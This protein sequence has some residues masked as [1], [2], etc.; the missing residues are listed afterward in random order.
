V[1]EVTLKP[2]SARSRR[3]APEERRKQ[4]V[5]AVIEVVAERGVPGAT[6]SRIA[7]A[8]GV[9][10]GTLYVY[11]PSRD[12]MLVAA[13]DSIFMQMLGL[14]ESSTEKDPVARLR[15]I[16]RRHSELMR[17][18][19]GGFLYPWIEFIAAG[20]LV[21]LREEVA[22]TQQRAFSKMLSIVEQGQAEGT[23]RPDL[24]AERLTWEW[25]TI[26]WAENMSC[27]MGLTEFIDDHHSEYLLELILSDAAAS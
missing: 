1:K 13:L 24:D 22:R 12:E 15:D 9:S 25:Y 2:A 6:V 10:E 16:G 26:I 18:E 8:A 17:T 20:P 11:Y 5:E 19:R 7:A 23:I 14:I 3:L 4:I 21:G 27:L